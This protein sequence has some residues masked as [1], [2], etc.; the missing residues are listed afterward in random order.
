[1]TKKQ[2]LYDKTLAKEWIDWV[3]SAQGSREQEI[4]PFVRNWLK[5]S[6][7]KAVVDIGCGQG[8]V[9]ELIDPKIEYIGVDPST[10][11][12][13]RANELYPSVNKKFIEGDAHAIPLEDASTDAAMS[14]W[15]WS[16][17]NDLNSAAREMFRILKPGG[18]FLI[19]TANPETYD[20]RKT[21]Y[22]KFTIKGNLLTGDFDLDNGKFLTNTTL[23]LHSKEQIENAIGQAGLTIDQITR[24][25]QASLS[26]K[27]LYLAIEG[28]K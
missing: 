1:M 7:P 25:G 26:D 15:V 5:K 23:Y 8:S 20:E 10:T 3:E 18:K 4:F 24:M 19:V 6:K 17:L 27:G 9:S 12:I 13:E 11:L 2:I 28:R 16:H 21:F 22:K 14:V